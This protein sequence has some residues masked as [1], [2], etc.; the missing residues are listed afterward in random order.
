[1]DQAYLRYLRDVR[2]WKPDIVIFGFISHDLLRTMSVYNFF[3]WPDWQLPAAKPRLVVKNNSLVPINVPTPHP[4]E[5]F[6]KSLIKD[7][8]FIE[9]DQNYYWTQWERPY[10]RY[11]HL[12]YLFR[13]LISWYPVWEVPREETSDVTMEALSREIS[14]SFV[15][16]ARAAGSIP[17]VVYFPLGEDLRNYS[18]NPTSRNPWLAKFVP[19]PNVVEVTDLTP[20]LHEVNGADRFLT[21]GH[22]SPKGYVAVAKCL[23][24][25][26]LN[27]V[28]KK[29]QSGEKRLDSGGAKQS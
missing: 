7:L 29:K 16:L 17:I 19:D 23:Q 28:S 2:P 21:D 25:V 13:F 22:Y 11:F 12:S 1:M 8:P 27:H 20:C 10:W 9:Y 18:L 26:V 6:S 15:Q 5:I 14:R 24:S 3:L 4:E